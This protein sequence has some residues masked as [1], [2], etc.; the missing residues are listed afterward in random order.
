MPVNRELLNAI[1]E[2]FHMNEAVPDRHIEHL[3]QSYIL[4]WLTERLSGSKQVLELGVGDGLVLAT[5]LKR[6]YELTVIEGSSILVNKVRAECGEAIEC[7]HTLFEEY[8]PTRQ[9]DAVIAS[10]VFEHVDDPIALLRHMRPWLKPD[11]RL[12]IFVPNK[13]SIHRQLAVLMGLQPELDTLS[14]RDHLVGHQRV[15]SHETL[16][17]ELTRAQFRVIESTGFFLK[18]LPNSMMLDYSMDLLHALNDIAPRI[19]QE[20]LANIGVVAVPIAAPAANT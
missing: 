15:Y 14:P 12:F 19:P 18:P 6:G 7:I 8:Q 13:M 11:G 4:R 1:A 3:F 5:L 17:A 9:F 16:S 2:N 20:L 10:F